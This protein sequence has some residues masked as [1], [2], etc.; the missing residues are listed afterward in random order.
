MN[1]TLLI[2]HKKKNTPK[3]RKAKF[4]DPSDG[5]GQFFKR[6]FYQGK[7]RVASKRRRRVKASSDTPL[8]GKSIKKSTKRLGRR[9]GD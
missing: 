2:V 3:T 9:R 8:K 5:G 1:K 7:D 6:V 4:L